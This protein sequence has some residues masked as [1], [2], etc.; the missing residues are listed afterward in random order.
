[1]SHIVHKTDIAC[2]SSADA[3][4]PGDEMNSCCSGSINIR[5]LGGRRD[6]FR[7][8]C[9]CSLPPA[10]GQRKSLPRD[11]TCFASRQRRQHIHSDD[12]QEQQ[13]LGEFVLRVL[14]V[15]SPS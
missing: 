12:G 13:V 14:N 10:L 4:V 15:T 3:M 11:F 9:K 5:S 7:A 1:M 8:T 2:M 6:S